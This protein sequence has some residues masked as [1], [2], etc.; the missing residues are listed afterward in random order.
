MQRGGKDVLSE[1]DVGKDTGVDSSDYIDGHESPEE[2]HG[3]SACPFT[4]PVKPMR[5]ARLA[6]MTCAHTMHGPRHDVV[7]HNTSSR[8]G[9]HT[10]ESCLHEVKSRRH[11]D[12]MDNRTPNLSVVNVGLRSR[13]A[14]RLKLVTLLDDRRESF[15]RADDLI[16]AVKLGSVAKHVPCP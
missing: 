11:V 12:N 14:T 5:S 15:S 4:P 2:P 3:Y 10:R 13:A 6:P 16:R 8:H 7:P 9:T 1:R